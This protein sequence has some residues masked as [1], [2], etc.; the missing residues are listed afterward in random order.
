MLGMLSYPTPICL[1][2]CAKYSACMDTAVTS[3][4]VSGLALPLSTSEKHLTVSRLTRVSLN[5]VRTYS[6]SAATVQFTVRPVYH[7]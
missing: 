4:E 2:F 6:I 5:A 1:D 3:L 7:S